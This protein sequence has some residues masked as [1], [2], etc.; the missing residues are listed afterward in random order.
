MVIKFEL[1][2]RECFLPVMKLEVA[3][4]L[5]FFDILFEC[6]EVFFECDLSFFDDSDSFGF[7][8]LL[9]IIGRFLLFLFPVT[10]CFCKF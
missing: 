7:V 6:E 9:E 1:L 8:M 2:V 4:L 10:R 3:V 5:G